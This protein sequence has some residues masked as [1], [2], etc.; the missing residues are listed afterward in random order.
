MSEYNFEVLV[1]LKPMFG[2]KGKRRYARKWELVDAITQ[3]K[4]GEL[5]AAREALNENRV[6]IAVEFS[7][8]RGAP[9]LVAG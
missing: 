7:P 4:E 8:A 9:Y 3:I 2:T 6:S 1:P 5:E